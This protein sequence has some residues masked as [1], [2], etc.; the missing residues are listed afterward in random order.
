MRTLAWLKSTLQV[1]LLKI[2]YD[3][4]LFSSRYIKWWKRGQTQVTKSQLALILNNIC[5]KELH[6][7]PQLKAERGEAKSIKSQIISDT[8]LKSVKKSMSVVK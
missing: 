6:K 2:P 1:V 7:F 4:K 5:L 3:M 8:Q